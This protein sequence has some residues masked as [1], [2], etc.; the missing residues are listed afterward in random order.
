[1]CGLRGGR[2]RQAERLERRPADGV[3][4]HRAPE[5]VRARPRREQADIDARVAAGRPRDACTAV[6]ERA[7]GDDTRRG[8]AGGVDPRGVVRGEA[9][10]PERL[11][12][13]RGRV[14]GQAVG[15][16]LGEASREALRGHRRPEQR[17]RLPGVDTVA[18]ERE[19]ARLVVRRRD[20]ERVSVAA[21]PREDDG[22]GGVV[23]E[24]VREVGRSVVSVAGVV[25]P[26][27]L[28]HQEEAGLAGRGRRREQV[29]RLGRHLGERGLIRLVAVDLVGEVVRGE[30]RRGGRLAEAVEALARGRH[31][32]AVGE[33]LAAEVA[34]VGA[35]A[36]RGRRGEEAPAAAEHHVE[37][38]VGHLGGDLGLVGALGD[39]A[40]V[41]GRRRVRDAARRDEA[42]GVARV[43]G[44][45]EDGLAGRPVR[46][47]GDRAVVGL[48]AAGVGRHA[49]CG[50]GD[51][52]VGRGR[53]D[54]PG[55]HRVERERPADRA[56]RE[57]LRRRP[58]AV[59]D[60]E[61]DV[62]R[63]RRGAGFGVLRADGRGGEQGESESEQNAHRRQGAGSRERPVGR[64]TV[65][66]TRQTRSG[67]RVSL[68][69]GVS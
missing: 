37:A 31:D 24:N 36:A 2:K 35:R 67:L 1:M 8:V 33:H 62:A 4:G 5:E 57:R 29:E 46:P 40:R 22:D 64:R 42:R 44:G 60:H 56:A 9:V 49:R 23:G 55:P 17:G 54:A 3:V 69:R 58:E 27:A 30:E 16:G 25:D 12:D 41:A 43:A 45:F 34:A 53:R 14:G 39:V 68:S 15:V 32:D 21:R 52:A 51:A 59:G 66:T 48:D 47:D 7:E 20:D 6:E 11:A 26:R 63:A 65:A 19:P 38:R 50:V 28:D 61:H 18:A 10:E 13:E